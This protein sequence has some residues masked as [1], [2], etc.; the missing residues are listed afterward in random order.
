MANKENL[1]EPWKPGQSGNPKGRPKNRVTN[2][3]LTACFGR[4][5]ARAIKALRREE[6]DTWEQIL[7][8]AKAEQLTVIAK[9]EG[10]PAY[11]KNLAMALLYDIKEGRTSTIDKLRERQYGKTT[12][13]LE[14]TGKDGMPLVPQPLTIEIIDSREQ[15]DGADP[16]DEPTTTQH[17]EN[18]DHADIP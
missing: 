17:G 2:E 13:R 7:L 3:W 8:V 14:V 12:E 18:T 4:K 9:W 10:T 15:V 1:V 5:A 11:A 6:I 16:S